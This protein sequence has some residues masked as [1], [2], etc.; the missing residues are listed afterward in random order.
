[1][2]EHLEGHVRVAASDR[3]VRERA[4]DRV[5]DGQEKR[6]SWHPR[7]TD[8]A[9]AIT[10]LVRVVGVLHF[11]PCDGVNIPG[12]VQAGEVAENTGCAT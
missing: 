6:R 2:P 5:D 7:V 10:P 4:R 8:N 12:P 11:G 1:V 9:R 3:D